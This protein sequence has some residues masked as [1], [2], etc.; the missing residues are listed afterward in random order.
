MQIIKNGMKIKGLIAAGGKGTRLRPLTFTSNKHL[1][2]IAN[3]PLLLYPLESLIS[4]GIKDIGVVVNESRQAVESAL[5]DGSK[6]GVKLTYINQPEPLGV[7]HVIKTARYFLGN[8]PFVFILGDNIFTRGIKGPFEHFLKTKADALLVM[9]E[10]EENFRLGVPFFENGKLI[11]VVE[12]PKHPPN[13]FGVPGLYLFSSKVHR[14]FLG[15]ERI[16]PS[17]RGEYEITD[18]YN[19]MLKYGYK[20]EVK[21][22]EGKWLD[23]GKFDDSLEANRLLLELNCKLDI[24]G[25]VDK[26]SKLSG[27]VTVGTHSQIFNS[28]LVGPI[29]IGEHVRINN[30]HIGPYTSIGDGCEITNTAIEYSIIMEDADIS[31]VPIRI[32]ASMIGK[33]A[34][35]TGTRSV[36]PAYRLTISDMSK[37]D[38]PR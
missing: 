35:I 36:N 37:V 2:P 20:V 17:A 7:A 8:D 34:S 24:K 26:Q 23:P 22:I 25:K 33:D 21:K 28:R 10:H 29:S 18:I 1:I 11:K 27:N 3:K 32:E 13:K 31:D 30:S 4:L 38:L 16:K 5:G 9:V 12:K 6:W 19:Y 14:A 15:K